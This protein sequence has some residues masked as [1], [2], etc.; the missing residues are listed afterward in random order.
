MKNYLTKKTV[1]TGL[2]IIAFQQVMI[3]D[4]GVAAVVGSTPVR[5]VNPATDPALTRDVDSPA[6]RPFAKRLC[7]SDIST[8]CTANV[9]F[10]AVPSS[11]IVPTT[12]AG[13]ES[14]KQLVIEFVSG[15]CVGTRRSTGVDIFARPSTGILTN[16]DTGDN[17][18]RNNFPLAVAQFLQPGGVNG[19]Q[20][21]AQSAR[22]YFNPGATV[23]IGFNSVVGGVSACNA[24]LNGYFVV[25]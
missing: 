23:S 11:F 13:G 14:V 22:I 20:A 12:T 4:D 2:T 7:Q 8:G 15:E 3:V 1:L 21:F 9:T 19:V 25:K 5:I 24:Q 18:S 6:N 16:P 17:F 10:P